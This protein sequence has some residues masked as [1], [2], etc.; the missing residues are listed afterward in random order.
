MKQFITWQVQPLII[1]REIPKSLI[2]VYHA[3]GNTQTQ[4]VSILHD[5]KVLEAITEVSERQK[6]INEMWLK[7]LE[8]VKTQ[9]ETLAKSLQTHKFTLDNG[10]VTSLQ[11]LISIMP[12]EN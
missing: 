10:T 5:S 4:F 8:P 9:F 3:L 12:V 1:S 7:A 2:D 6:A 11:D